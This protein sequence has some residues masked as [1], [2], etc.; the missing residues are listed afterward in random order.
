[1]P[2]GAAGPALPCGVTPS[3]WVPATIS[4]VA[5]GIS[6]NSQ[7]K[8]YS[9]QQPFTVDLSS[10]KLRYSDQFDGFGMGRGSWRCPQR[11]R[12]RA[13]R[14]W[15]VVGV[16]VLSMQFDTVSSQSHISKGLNVSIYAD[17]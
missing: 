5:V 10:Q 9:G 4:R 17:F 16:I 14:H 8:N 1:M 6:N 11:Y 3:L 2:P 13:N 12:L 15:L 7:W